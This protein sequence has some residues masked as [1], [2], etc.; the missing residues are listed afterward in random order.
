MQ[1]DIFIPIYLCL[2]LGLRRG[3]ML[4]L[5]WSDIYL[6]SGLIHIQRTATPPKG[7]YINIDEK[8]ETISASILNKLIGMQDRV[9]EIV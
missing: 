5:R 7:G 9:V 3:E 6:D 1:T 8:G 4:G 2:T